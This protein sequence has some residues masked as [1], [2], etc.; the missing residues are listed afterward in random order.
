MVE[1]AVKQAARAGPRVPDG[2]AGASGA[3]GAWLRAACALGFGAVVLALLWSRTLDATYL[4][5]AAVPAALASVLARRARP[6]SAEAAGPERRGRITAVKAGLYAALAALL[7]ALAAGSL[8]AYRLSRI[9]ADW[10]RLVEAREARLAA[11]LDRRMSAVLARGRRAAE[12]AA[13][14]AAVPSAD[15]F[16]ELEAVRRRTGVAALAV[17]REAGDLVAW[18]G[19]HRGAIPYDLRGS[20]EGTVYAEWPLFSYLY[21]S[22]P[23]EGRGERVIAAILLETSIPLQ[24]K[25]EAGF[26]AD[27]ARRTG[28]LP[29]FGEGA[30]PNAAWHLV[31]SGDTILH[32]R[33]EPISQARLRAAAAATG[34]RMV[35]ALAAL[36]LLLFSHAW[37][38]SR[39]SGAATAVPLAVALVALAVAPLGPALKLETLFSP[40]L[41]LLPFPVDV[42]LG[43]FFAVLLP[44][45]ALAM[46]LRPPALAARAGRAWLAAGALAVALAFPL[47]MRVVTAAA[48]PSL[49]E[50]SA[51]LWWVLQPA[52]VLMLSL[53][54]G[55][56]FPQART[57]GRAGAAAGPGGARE[58]VGAGRAQGRTAPGGVGMPRADAAAGVWPR[59]GEWLA[60]SPVLIAGGV[61]SSIALAALLLLRWPATRSVSGWLPALWAVPFVLLALG[62]ASRRSRRSRLMRWLA[63]GWL[64]ASL[65]TPYLWAAHLGARLRAA[66]RDIATLG[67]R[68]DPLLDYLLRHFAEEAIRRHAAGEDG[69]ALLYRSWVASDLAREGYPARIT[70]WTVGRRAE[71]ELPVGGVRDAVRRGDTPSRVVRLV[72][73][74]ARVARAPVIR[75]VRDV[76]GVNQILA[77]PL[78][79]GREISVVVPPRRT[80]TR[81]G[82]LAPFLDAEPRAGPQLSLIPAKADAAIEPDQ[83]GWRATEHGWRS[84]TLVHIPGEGNYHAHVDLRTPPRSVRVARALLLLALDLALLALLWAVGRAA[85]GDPPAPPGGWTAWLG[86]FRARVTL[87]LFGFFLLPTILFGAVAYRGFAGE[88]ERAARV[89]AERA[90]AQAAAVFPESERRLDALAARIGEDIL[91][92]HQGELADASSREAFEMGIYSAW[93][94]PD[95]FATL[96]SGEETTVIEER[97]LVDRPY[98][99]AYRALRPT[100]TLAVPVS[101][102]ASD[103]AIR[104]RELAHVMLLTALV[105]GLLSLALSVFVGRALAH[106][107]GQLRRAA[108]AVGAGRLRAR[109]PED[110]ADE[111]GELFAAFNRMVRRLREARAKE[112]RTA[113]VLAWG[114]MARQVAHEIK[115][116]L[117][118]IKLSVQHLR[119]AYADRHPG[120]GAVLETN[121]EQILAEIDRLTEIAR[122]F[123]RYGAPPEAAG[124]LE[125]VDVATVVREALTL[126][127]AGDVGVRY[128]AVVEEGL[129]RAVARTGELKEVI[130]NLL[131]NA[132]AA[133]DGAGHVLVR[134]RR[135]DGGIEV[136]VQDDG[137]G[138][139]AELVSRVFEPHFSTRSAGTGLGLAIVRRLVE[140]WGGEVSA[141]SREGKG[142]VV[143][144]RMRIAER[145]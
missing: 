82:A 19:D 23:V 87:A 46:T 133:L 108:T 59:A 47:C 16:A 39:P 101:L 72:L 98:L 69:L 17:F 89:L 42:S 111:F 28:V 9:T 131:E 14:S 40:T 15:R 121:V 137:P 119:R 8:T 43:R 33:F 112:V 129:P 67:S 24:E 5:A 145:S 102:S 73:D 22:Q 106:P 76:P 138:I 86:T 97:R 99:I 34:R 113:R 141:E 1:V 96:Q 128:E 51:Y 11:Q 110:R 31:E 77:V 4:A 25:P 53:V 80:L 85:R 127:R 136:A 140:S 54:A 57:A 144:I 116:P 114:E 135:L 63:A 2:G 38:R 134:A 58:P 95:V 79:D 132:H 50:S 109:L 68:A 84:E 64:A 55:L 105:G 124:P 88:V 81:A 104:Q 94:P 143:R 45:T 37:L 61:L 26:A 27:F 3:A 100:G 60:S 92:Y 20:P 71:F 125:A 48:G 142:A 122:A 49:L 32:A 107:I 103:A 70:L 36:A 7:F 30:S 62:L 120:F 44:L 118:P 41:F 18:A 12:L 83:I 123:S 130:L 117:T 65:A 29:L 75:V 10:D 139:P 13:R 21:F 35:L 74:S 126:Y 56:A 52:A 93:M 66:E 90:V 6:R 91:Y 115:N 78:G